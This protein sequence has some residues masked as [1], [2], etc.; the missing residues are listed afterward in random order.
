[1]QYDYIANYKISQEK[2]D[3]IADAVESKT[4]KRL[5]I[6]KAFNK[7]VV[8]N[9]LALKQERKAFNIDSCGTFIELSKGSDGIERIT[10]ANFCRDRLCSI[11]AWRR[12][13]RFLAT[14]EPAL[15][16]IDI[17][18]SGKAQ[19]IF[20]TLTV[21]NCAGAQLKDTISALMKGWDRLYKRKPFAGLSLGCIRSCEVTYNQLTDT[22]HPHIH[23]LVLVKNEYFQVGN[24]ITENQ[25]SAIWQHCLNCD[26]LPITNITAVTQRNAGQSAVVSASLEVMKYSLK[27]K[28][29]AISPEVTETLF[30]A[31]HSRRLIS[32]SGVIARARKELAFAD[33]YEDTL[34]DDIN[35]GIDA[36]K[37]LYL[38]SASG[39]KIVQE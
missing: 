36:R 16:K 14:T 24:Y 32:F 38:F 1:M 29:Y 11:C 31:L 33:L 34:V 19:Y 8:E 39:W 27:T 37:E 4:L 23:A 17:E 6:H 10:R 5:T 7:K 22:Y 2:F 18:T 3:T 13:A 12:Q 20:L 21:K 26:Y 15:R 28:D 35:S 9:L 25:L 30:Y